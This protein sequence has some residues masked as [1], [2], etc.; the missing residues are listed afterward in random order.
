MA[1]PDDWENPY[2]TCHNREEMH[3][4]LEA[5]PDEE[6][7]RTAARGESPNVRLLNGKWRFHFASSPHDLTEPFFQ[8]DYDDSQWAEMPVP[9]NWELHGYDRPIYTNYRY[10]FKPVNPPY[11]PDE[12]P[13]GFYRTTFTVPEQWQ[14]K[15]VYLMFEGVES[16]FHVWVNG[17]MI[18]YSQ[19]SK[20]PAEFDVSDA[21]RIGDNTLCVMVVRWSDGAYLEDQD[22][23]HVSGI[24]RDVVLYAKPETHVRDVGVRT[25]LH[26]AYTDAQLWVRTSVN[27][28]E[29]MCSMYVKHRLFDPFGS[30]VSLGDEADEACASVAPATPMGRNT[31]M[32][33]ASA[34]FKAQIVNPY[35]WT[36]DTPYL[37]TLI[38]SLINAD[39]EVVDVERVRVGF[40]QVEIRDGVV[41]LNGKRLVVR[42]VDRHEFHPERGR[43]LTEADMVAEIKAMKRLNFN[44]VRTSHYPDCIRWYELCDEY[45]IYIVDEAN[46]ETHGLGARLSKDPA[47]ASAYLERARRMVVRDRNHPS[48]IIWS[49]GNES[50]A[51]PHH[52]AMAAWIR[53][54]DP[55]R[56]VQY[57]SGHPESDISDIMAPMYPNLEWVKNEFARND[58]QR[59][60]IMCEYAY[61]KGNSNGNF[62]KFWDMVLAYPRFQGG[63]IWDWADKAIL[64]DTEKG[65][66]WLYGNTSDELEHMHR[67]CLNGVVWPDLTP[68]PGALEIQKVQAPVAVVAPDENSLQNGILRI[69]NRY[70]GG[71]LSHLR[72]EWAVTE[73]GVAVEQGTIDMPHVPAGMGCSDEPGAPPAFPGADLTIPYTT[74]DTE[75]ADVEAHLTVR[76]VLNT[77]TAW[78]REGHPVTWE[79][80]RLPVNIGVPSL[81]LL[82][83]HAEKVDVEETGNCIEIRTAA[84]T[85]VFDRTRGQLQELSTGRCTIPVS[86]PA[87]NLFRAPTDIDL[88]THA[89]NYG[90]RWLAAGLDK[91]QRDVRSVQAGKVDEATV[92]IRIITSLAP[93]TGGDRIEWL[94]TYTVHGNG[95]IFVENLCGI[96]ATYPPLPRVGARLRL[97]P[98]FSQFTWL[99]RGPQENYP[100]R[101]SGAPVGQYARSVYDL[102]TPYIFPQECGG[103]TDVRWCKL[104]D[105]GGNGLLVYG[106]PTMHVSALPYS[107][108]ELAAADYNWQLPEPTETV[109]CLDG[110]HTGVG[111]DN[112]WAPNIHPEFLIQPGCHRFGYRLTVVEGG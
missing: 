98:E 32:E 67:M 84:S 56:P 102:Y 7:A 53:R 26:S 17:R 55:T 87:E 86:G 71:D 89:G 9:S 109:L 81:K 41:L 25:W 65:P 70:L 111:G 75:N 66:C 58:E 36:A 76:C 46:V 11:V 27:P 92:V 63:F 100:D 112:G 107:Q 96:P 47:W 5:F 21:L 23:W 64:G 22:Y 8:E 12:N 80:F 33:Y 83:E 40:R 19:D 106:I 10:P 28:V 95:E 104:T 60:M 37:Y 97:P 108:E 6:T 3:Q 2:I 110:N 52:A 105:D 45:G 88:G 29:N 72:V 38:V 14:D 57:E 103:R 93:S 90:Q 35:K 59:P 18:G 48:V 30:E 68:K 34:L 101:K 49:L 77:D 61:S 99:G 43:A 54:Y 78:G 50:G 44:A 74:P 79:Q 31:E 94:T 91:L 13:T 73:D 16:A 85:L 42:G 39:G 4:F 51:G 69:E 24:Q 15:R 1:R 62:W 20:L 82:A